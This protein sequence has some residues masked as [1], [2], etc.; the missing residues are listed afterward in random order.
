METALFISFGITMASCLYLII[1]GN[2]INDSMFMGLAFFL[3]IGFLFFL[4]GEYIIQ[5]YPEDELIKSASGIL[6][7]LGQVFIASVAVSI[8]LSIKST[9]E[10]V[11]NALK[12]L[13]IDHNYFD[14]LNADEIKK[15]HEKCHKIQNEGF[16]LESELTKSMVSNFHEA[17]KNPICV[18]STDI[19][20]CKREGDSFVK[21]FR[22]K[23]TLKNPRVG[24]MS[25]AN[26]MIQSVMEVPNSSDN[27][28]YFKL[29]DH[30]ITIDEKKYTRPIAVVFKPNDVTSNKTYNTIARITEEGQDDFFINFSDKAVIEF[31]YETTVSL[32]DASFTKRFKYMT[33]DYTLNFI[34]EG[35]DLSV[36]PQFFAGFVERK[37]ISINKENN[38]NNAFIQY[39]G[40]SLPGSGISIVLNKLNN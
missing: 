33:Q 34:Y 1:K 27:N 13:L 38:A 7:S 6:N 17:F 3:S 25:Q 23:Y 9:R 18:E 19:I 10:Y 35:S 37:D 16:R 20:R 4:I 40:L 36:V 31:V 5:E 8:F 21:N 28:K 26:I 30:N 24:Y 32:K 2:K 12:K 39:K 11:L 29:L 15:I 14:K 22:V